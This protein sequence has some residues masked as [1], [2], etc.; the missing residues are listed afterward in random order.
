[1]SPT[2]FRELI[3]D[4]GLSILTRF[5]G[6]VSDD[7]ARVLLLAIAGQE[8]AWEH[9]RQISGPAR[10]FF[11]FERAGGTRGVLNHHA[12]APRALKLLGGLSIPSNESIVFEAMAWS[13]H[14]AVGFARLLLYTDPRRLPDVGE[15][16]QAWN[17]YLRNWRPGKPHPDHWPSRYMAALAEITNKA[18]L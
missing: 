12:S 2:V 8:S 7:R 11:Q 16:D 6:L 13:D 10:G 4:P 3:L 9:R 15:Q 5:S 18:I 14:L 1:M 17:Y